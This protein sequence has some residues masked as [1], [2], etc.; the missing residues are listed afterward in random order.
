MSFQKMVLRQYTTGFPGELV[1]EGPHR[2]KPGRIASVSVGADPGLSTNRISRAFGWSA[3]MA[4]QG[5][6]YSAMEAQVVVGA[7]IFYGILGHPKHYALTGTV[8]GGPLAASMDLPQYAEGEFFD[9][10]SGLVV[11]LFNETTGS[12]TTAF[13]DQIAYVSN[14]ITTLQN[15]LALPYGALISVAAGAAAPAGFILI[16]N[17]RVINP[18]SLT[19]SAL[20]ALVSGYAVAQ[21]TQ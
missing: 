14:A 9:M 4:A 20:G 5:S 6:T 2:A 7:P 8:A 1:R 11:E 21:L 16:P 13:G 10:A 18:E 12:K 15:T 17:A 3:D 19:A